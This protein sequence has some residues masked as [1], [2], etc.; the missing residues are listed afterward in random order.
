MKTETPN[1]ETPNTW[2]A[3]DTTEKD[4]NCAGATQSVPT[5]LQRELAESMARM[6]EAAEKP[7]LP[8]EAVWLNIYCAVANCFNSEKHNAVD[9]ADVGLMEFRKRFRL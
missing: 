2:P 4:C 7:K 3:L 6:S 9:W 8:D 1:T 5:Q